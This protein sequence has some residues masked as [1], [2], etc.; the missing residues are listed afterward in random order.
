MVVPTVPVRRP[1]VRRPAH[2]ARAAQR[3]FDLQGAR[4]ESPI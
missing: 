3:A 2:E 4:L 1:A